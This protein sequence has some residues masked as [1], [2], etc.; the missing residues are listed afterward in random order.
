M[1]RWNPFRELEEMM[2]RYN[3]LMPALPSLESTFEPGQEVM[4]K[5]DWMPA[6]DISE[7]PQA[8]LVKAELPEIGRD[9]VKLNVRD[10][11]LT[12]S[13][14]R[15]LEKETGDTKHHR[16][17]RLYG[18]FSRSFTLPD[19]ASEEAVDAQFKEGVLTITIPKSQQVKP[20]S[21]D[22]SIH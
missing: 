4:T 8:Y 18:S 7:T 22:V 19:D 5:A 16:I 12:L 2:S 1:T 17:E 20:R 9:D 10:H 13:G 14:E 6:V 15:H 3:R 21:I 11:V